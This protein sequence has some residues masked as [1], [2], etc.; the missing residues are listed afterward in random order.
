MKQEKMNQIW[1][2][3]IL[4]FHLQT[5]KKNT[6]KTEEKRG[7]KSQESSQSLEEVETDLLA[8]CRRRKTKIGHDRWSTEELSQN[9]WDGGFLECPT[10]RLFLGMPDGEVVFGNAW[11]LAFLN[12][13]ILEC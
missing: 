6:I 4:H 8:P 11:F 7:E 13:G 2:P 9:S 3:T 1:F 5:L 10:E 12:A